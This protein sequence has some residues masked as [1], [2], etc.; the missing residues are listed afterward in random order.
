MLDIKT[1][2]TLATI[3]IGFV[4]SFFAFKYGLKDTVKRTGENKEN[5][6]KL[7][8]LTDDI[9]K[10]YQTVPHCREWRAEINK[11]HDETRDNFKEATGEIKSSIENIDRKIEKYIFNGKK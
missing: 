5:I 9:K 1:I 3:I 7:W 6:G 11:K 2:I 4:S 10:D 8:D